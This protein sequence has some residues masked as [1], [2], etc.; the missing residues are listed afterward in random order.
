MH[1]KRMSS[2]I[3]ALRSRDEA[4]R[5]AAAQNLKKLGPLAVPAIEP[6][7]QAM[8]DEDNEVSK[9]ACEALRSMG[10]A[11]L[12]QLLSILKDTRQEEKIRFNAADEIAASGPESTSTLV[13]LIRDHDLLVRLAA[14]EA[15]PH[16]KVVDDN[17]VR[18][19]E[20][21]MYDEELR[22]S[23]SLSLAM[24]ISDSP[25]DESAKRSMAAKV[26]FGALKSENVTSRRCAAQSLEFLGERLAAFREEIAQAAEDADTEVR[27]SVGNVR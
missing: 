12:P 7:L 25:S 26:F 8:E 18:I 3:T 13:E 21:L 14:V 24:I 19:L 6:L 4:D 17:T 15:I 2:L 11:A 16:L 20:R 22:R 5:L 1:N 27:S 10:R 9:T 23:A